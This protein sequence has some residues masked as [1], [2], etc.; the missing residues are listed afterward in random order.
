MK[1]MFVFRYSI[2][3]FAGASL[4]PLMTA[5]TSV[6]CVEI[7]RQLAVKPLYLQV[8]NSTTQPW[9][10]PLAENADCEIIGN[11]RALRALFAPLIQFFE[12]SNMS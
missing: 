8:T 12:W 6:D 2:L 1:K 4:F 7:V 9:W 11:V 3:I 5:L 10:P